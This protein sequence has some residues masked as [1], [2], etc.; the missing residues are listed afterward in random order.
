MITVPLEFQVGV[1]FD[2]TTPDGRKVRSIV[3]K[4]NDSFIAVQTAQEP[5]K[6]STKII[7]EFKDDQVIITSSI[8][9]NNDLVCLQTFKKVK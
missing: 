7:R 5:G 6:K 2:E 3:T 9:G 8:I 4:E 1:E